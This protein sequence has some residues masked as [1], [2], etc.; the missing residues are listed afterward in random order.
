MRQRSTFSELLVGFVVASDDAAAL[1]LLSDKEQF[2]QASAESCRVGVVE[3]LARF[4]CFWY[5]SYG[6]SVR[7]LGSIRKDERE[8]G[9][10]DVRRITAELE[11]EGAA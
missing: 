9:R 4:G 2:G 3:V 5:V 8:R 7:A 11:G 10:T 6:L 1:F